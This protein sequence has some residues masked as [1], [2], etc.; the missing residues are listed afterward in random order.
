MQSL[1]IGLV[2]TPCQDPTES[3]SIEFLFPKT[4]NKTTL[5]I[6]TPASERLPKLLEGRPAGR[7]PRHRCG[8]AASVP[9]S[10]GR[11]RPGEDGGQ[12]PRSGPAGS[13]VNAPS[14]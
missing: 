5:P 7:P 1:T 11:G 9:R 10:R 14:V 2:G 4:Q 13:H 6:F 8:E 3:S 12:S